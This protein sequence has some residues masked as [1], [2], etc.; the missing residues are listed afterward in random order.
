MKLRLLFL[1]LRAACPNRM[2]AA[3][4]RRQPGAE[5]MEIGCATIE[6][7]PP[8]PAAGAAM[9]ETGL[10]LE[11]EAC[12]E[13]AALDGRPFDIVVTLCRQAGDR[14]PLLSGR[15]AVIQWNLPDPAGFDADPARRVAQFREL[16]DAIR[17]LVADLFEQGYVAAFASLRAA[18]DLILDSISDGILAHDLQRRIVFFN[19]AAETITGRT[20]ADVL[21]RDC[22]AVF[23]CG[24]CGAK[25]ALDNA[26]PDAPGFE[27]RRERMELA[28][29]GGARRTLDARILPLRDRHGRWV[30]L[31]SVFHDVTREV[32]LERRMAAEQS[33]AGIVGRDPKMQ[34]VFQLVRDVADSGVPILIQGESGTGK[35]LVAAAIHN[36]GPRAAGPFVAVNCGALPE[37]LLESEMFGHVRGAFTGAI[38]DKKGRFEL[39]DGGTIF[40]D[41]IGDVSPAMQMR[42]LRVLQEGV[43]ERV[44]GE[45][46]IRVDV[47]VISATHR[48]LRREIEA[49][50]FRE[51]LYY[52]LNVVPIWMPPLRERLA[53]LPLL[54]EHLLGRFLREMGRPGT[55][56]VSAAAMDALLAHDWPGNVRE[57]ENWLQYALVK[58]RGDAIGPEHLP[59][60]H[61]ASRRAAAAAA[62]AAPPPAARRPPLNVE[63][64]R[65]ALAR[66]GGNRRDAARELGV[67]RATLYR[68]FEAHRGEFGEEPATS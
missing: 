63:R 9:A 57:L 2:A 61:L 30:G 20:E 27:E 50:R 4:A 12:P 33:F 5:E 36:E 1:G 13:L 64:V 51:D 10:R 68:F 46:S 52:R 60:A 45:Q 41:E 38:R 65:E 58:C 44:G 43:I 66:T 37:G 7:A 49:G 29:V 34:G 47:R 62:P 15:P 40:L 24:F 55:L 32:H 56:R 17:R 16:R 48:D 42:L 53:D 31:V 3:F 21:G 18:S 25:C 23:G 28:A 22:H 54:V 8:D 59:P 14:Q 11:E 19:R 26:A 39:A 6:A 35:E 67:A